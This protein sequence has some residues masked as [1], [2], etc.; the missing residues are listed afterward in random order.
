MSGCNVGADTPAYD[1]RDLAKVG[2]GGSNPL[3]RSNML[4][5]NQFIMTRAA[6]AA[7]LVFGEVNTL[8]KRNAAVLPP[9]RV[10]SAVV[11]PSPCDGQPD[12]TRRRLARDRVADVAA[13]QRPA[14][15]ADADHQLDPSIGDPHEAPSGFGRFV[16]KAEAWH[17]RCC[18]AIA[19]PRQAMNWPER[20]QRLGKG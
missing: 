2:V 8:S 11:P 9:L 18:N 7:H 13:P 1:K 5:G 3:A 16:R 17:R 10:Q 19:G 20:S 14:P 6:R 4:Q 15:V 12:E